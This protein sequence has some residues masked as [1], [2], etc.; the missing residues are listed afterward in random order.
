MPA[1]AYATAD[2]DLLA[3]DT[4][5]YSGAAAGD[6]AGATDDAG[7]VNGDGY[8]DIIIGQAGSEQSG[9]DSGSAIVIYG[10]EGISD[11]SLDTITTGSPAQTFRGFRI[12]G[13][14]AGDIAG[15]D[16]GAAGDINGDGFDD[17]YV[18]APGADNGFTNSGSVY[19][20]YGEQPLNPLGAITGADD[21]ADLN[22][23]NLTTTANSRGFRIDGAAAESCLGWEGS[24]S[25]AGDFND[26]GR[27]DLLVGAY[28]CGA[29][30]SPGHAYVIYG[31]A[32]P[33]GDVPDISLAGG[34]AALG[35]QFTGVAAIDGV[36]FSTASAG[37]FNGDGFDDILLSAYHST[38]GGN[39]FAGAAYVVYGEDDPDPD[40]LGLGALTG[41]SP[42]DQA[43][44]MVMP[45]AGENFLT[46]WSVDG[47]GDVNA[48]GNDD[49]V[50]GAPDV[51][52]LG[53]AG[54]GMAY[55]VYGEGG[56]GDPA[57]LDLLTPG[58]RAQQITGDVAG[59]CFG[60]AVAGVGDIDG[61]GRDDVA[62]GA[63][64]AD[65]NATDSGAAYVVY[66]RDEGDPGDLDVSD[67]LGSAD[68][69][70]LRIGGAAQDDYAGN[71]IGSIEMFNFTHDI[72]L[73]A[74]VGADAN[75]T[76]SGM[77]DLLYSGL[78]VIFPGYDLSFPTTAVG[79]S[80]TASVTITNLDREQRDQSITGLAI[81]GVDSGRFAITDG[82]EEDPLVYMA[83]CEVGIEFSPESLASNATLTVGTSLGPRSFKVV[84]YGPGA[85]TYGDLEQLP[86]LAGCITDA[87]LDF[88]AGT[89][90]ACT[91]SPQP[92]GALNAAS[93]FALSPDGAFGYLVTRASTLTAYTVNPGTGE[94]TSLTG[95]GAC[96]EGSGAI[97]DPVNCEAVAGQIGGANGVAVS[98]DGEFVYVGGGVSNSVAAFDRDTVTGLL[99]T[100]GGP[101]GC[102]NENGSF[103]CFNGRGMNAFN[104]MV[105]TADGQHIYVGSAYN[106]SSGIA[107][108]N[109]NPATGA[110]SQP[111]G[112]GGT[113]DCIT[114]NGRDFPAGTDNQCTNATMPLVGPQTLAVDPDGDH[115][116]AAANRS[117]S[118]TTL[119]I[120]PDGSL[121]EA[122][123]VS[124]T[125]DGPCERLRGLD[126]PNGIAVSPSGGY[127]YVGTNTAGSGAI[128]VFDRNDAT[129]EL[130][131]R[132]GSSACVSA[133]PYY[134]RCG[135][136]RGM[137]LIRLSISPDGRNLYAGTAN[138]G[139][140]IFDLE[141]DGDISLSSTTDGCVSENGQIGN[142]EDG[143]ALMDPVAAEFSP[144]G[145]RVY[146]PSNVSHGIAIFERHVD[147]AAPGAPNI[148]SG[149]NG[150]TNDNDPSFDFS[151]PD[152]ATY[153]CRVDPGDP[154]ELCQPPDAYTNLPDG[155]YAFEVRA[156]DSSVNTGPSATR[157]FSID[158]T[159]PSISLNSPANG[160]ATSDPTPTFGGTAGTA[161]NDQAAIMVRIYSGPAPV[162]LPMQTL[163]A[164]A[165][166]GG[167]YS[168]DALTPL[169][170]GEYT[171]RAEQSDAAT[172][173][174]VSNAR[175]F[176]VD[177]QPPSA[178]AITA[179]PPPTATA[180]PSPSFEFDPEPGSTAECSIDQGLPVFGSCSGIGSHSPLFALAD[181]E[182]TF[183]LRQ[184]DAAGNQ[185][186]ETRSFIIDT[187]A[188]DTVVDFGP[189]SAS[190]DPNP[191]FGFTS[192]DAASYECQLD[193]AGYT[194][195]SSP[196]S[197]PGLAP[198]AH[199]FEV[200]GVD[201]AGNSDGSPATASFVIEPEAE[202]TPEP[203]KDNRGVSGDDTEGKVKIKTPGANRFRPLRAN[204]T[205]PLGSIVD[206][207]AEGAQVEV[208]TAVNKSGTRTR[209]IIFSAG[210][211]RLTQTRSGITRAALVHE[212][213]S[214]ET[215]PA[216]AGSKTQLR[217]PKRPKKPGQ[218]GLFANGG[219]GH[220]T[221]GQN[222]SA[223]VQ[224]TI[225]RTEDL[226]NGAT[227]FKLFEGRLKIRDFDKK[228]TVILRPKPN[229]DPG[230]YVARVR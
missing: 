173:T 61:D 31:Q 81:G 116:Y 143:R 138:D 23:A 160:M 204:E 121:V 94:L 182:Y 214:C 118:V 219:G 15:H 95:T 112:I 169:A 77:V 225:W 205:I 57:D 27:D 141:P 217:R 49:I 194:P 41:G 168:G 35:A 56:G 1:S 54:P 37:D 142:C 59:D 190:K 192:P 127:V 130:T 109:V 32:P 12:N 48:D 97:N 84:L 207:S 113:Q 179:A 39:P 34:P 46:G 89:A 2:W 129:G 20:I 222:G 96:K 162:G 80:A 85:T 83:D 212:E 75:G 175:T 33:G 153:R 125:G 128:A 164:G 91:D 7:D 14:A 200:R 174:G 203:I 156:V 159:S 177:T 65:I 131:Q 107:A 102:I 191:I 21:I 111:S 71:Y 52:N 66:G 117:D 98:P 227:R 167:V 155:P 199:T 5:R 103:L 230:V 29:G 11:T 38:Q 146:I 28:G 26:D 106:G 213:G 16:V 209:S 201:A 186:V 150:L 126:S 67:I 123:C 63:P 149:P 78:P 99:T 120:Q 220:Q 88:P 72:L 163:A 157:P 218:G 166:G 51:G 8:P 170:D 187:V 70:G 55:V 68:D 9:A 198:G 13:V 196:M 110:L 215:A 133:F 25:P 208:I 134:E 184:T 183:R 30:A 100:I 152:A 136:S 210:V 62:V 139:V 60:W 108:V 3:D 105:M 74:S 151:E 58:S 18:S 181:G 202:R 43:R 189:A 93:A 226:C 90:G 115:V 211:F 206:T 216:V 165:G 40:D 197:Y 148:T 36:G 69:R 79:G 6:F 229:G 92:T 195:C 101:T 4:F 104:D 17:I 154:F 42:S 76:D 188:P 161:P 124:H 223:T 22:L 44:G 87:G 140:L 171:A 122:S 114:H 10:W 24:V 64:Y 180:N 176:T 228:R 82:C 172:N 147:N 50:V 19:V 73:V 45:G 135:I 224:G 193:G 145:E 178:H 132:S 86:G 137:N 47:A 119:E 185:S 158:T 53:C 144:D 221:S